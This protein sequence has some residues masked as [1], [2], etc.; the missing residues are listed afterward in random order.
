M[1]GAHRIKAGWKKR[2]VHELIR[3][4]MNVLY[5][6]VFFGLFSSYRRLIL[7]HYEIDYGNYGIS[8]IKA[9]V[10]AK[11]MMIGDVLRL[12][13]GLE[14]RPLIFPTLYRAVLFTLWTALF[15]VFESTAR[16]LVNRGGLSAGLADI[17]G[18]RMEFLANGLVVFVAFIP[19][20]S[21]RELGRVLGEGRIWAL[22][23]AKREPPSSSHE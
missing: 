20:F 3:Y 6:A 21:I 17:L 10:L 5:L 13:R 1:R 9:M 15:A 18:R 16:G 12:G 4:W 11:V 2:I 14:H 7:A 8:I 23:F 22:F 19:F